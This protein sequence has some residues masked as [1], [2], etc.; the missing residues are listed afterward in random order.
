MTNS[1]ST[2]HHCK[3]NNNIALMFQNVNVAKSTPIRAIN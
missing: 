3:F 1:C 2:D